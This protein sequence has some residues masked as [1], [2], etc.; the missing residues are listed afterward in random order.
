[1]DLGEYHHV[2]EPPDRETEESQPIA[3]GGTSTF[4]IKRKPVSSSSIELMSFSGQK[5]LR[6]PSYEE[7]SEPF[8]THPAGKGILRART[9]KAGKQAVTRNRPA[10]FTTVATGLVLAV[11]VLLVNISI[12]AW[13]Y[14]RL[15]VQNSTAVLFTG[16][17]AKTS[18]ITAA[19]ELAIN[20][21]STLLLAASN[22]CGQLLISPTRTEI[23]SAHEKGVWLHVG[24][25][26]ARNFKGIGK[27][28]I[29][30]W[31]VLFVSSVPLHLL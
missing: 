6:D 23:D 14:S 5:A 27:W 7:S 15:H 8:F 2:N 3:V 11:I 20:I 29:A 9:W 18:T 28:R 12:L 22:N 4:G 10:W 1:M 30:M 25:T 16:S 19:A 24:I 21:L 13:T 31:A 17:C 26:S